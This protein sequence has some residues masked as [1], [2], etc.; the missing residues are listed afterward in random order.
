MPAA[1]KVLDDLGDANRRLILEHLPDGPLPVGALTDR[2]GL[3]A[4]RDYLD[5]FWTTALDNVAAPAEAEAADP[6]RV[7]PW[8]GGRWYERG[9]DGAE[10]EARFAGVAE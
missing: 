6:Q 9:V 2:S 4:V 7:E 8:I 10:R 1:A 3:A 5:R